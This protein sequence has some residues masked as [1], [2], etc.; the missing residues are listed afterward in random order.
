MQGTHKGV[1]KVL[2]I[3]QLLV[4]VMDQQGAGE[5]TQEEEAEV[6]RDGARQDES[7]HRA[8]MQTHKS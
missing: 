4:A 3:G 8:E 1:S 2:D 7:D 5:H 6:G